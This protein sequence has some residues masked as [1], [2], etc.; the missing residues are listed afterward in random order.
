MKKE[1][2]TR[3]TRS[4]ILCHRLR[5]I[6]PVLHSS[7]SA[8][9]LKGTGAYSGQGFQEVGLRTGEEDDRP[10][11]NDKQFWERRGALIPRS[12]ILPYLH[13]PK[14]KK[15]KK[16]GRR[17]GVDRRREREF[18]VVGEVRG[19]RGGPNTEIA[20]RSILGPAVRLAA[21]GSH[22]P[23]CLSCIHAPW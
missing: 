1:S 12:I 4:K 18:G 11:Y 17:N 15:K 21:E 9:P 6:H 3:Y 13:A 10:P 20:N 16:K 22:C 19:E 7:H 23:G 5:G 2:S 8:P 14:Y